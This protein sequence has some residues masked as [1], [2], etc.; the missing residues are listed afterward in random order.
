[1]LRDFFASIVMRVGLDVTKHVLPPV[2]TIF[3]WNHEEGRIGYCG[4]RYPLP[5]LVVG[6][7]KNAEMRWTNNEGIAPIPRSNTLIMVLQRLFWRVTQDQL[8]NLPAYI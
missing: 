1:M 2:Q 3:E 4:L 7:P 5:E 6:L 8:M